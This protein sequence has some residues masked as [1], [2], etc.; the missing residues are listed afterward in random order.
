VLIRGFVPNET[1]SSPANLPCMRRVQRPIYGQMLTSKPEPLSSDE[2][3][4]LLAVSVSPPSRTIPEE[5]QSRLL[6]LGYIEDVLGNLFVTD[7]GV[8]RIALG[9]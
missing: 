5:I 7:D 1:D 9:N 8:K 4:A 3:A 6:K 2:F